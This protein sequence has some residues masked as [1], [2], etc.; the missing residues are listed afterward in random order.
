[1]SEQPV[2]ITIKPAKS[3]V[4]VRKPDGS[5]LKADGE[6]VTKNAF[7]VRRLNDGDVELVKSTKVEE[8]KAETKKV[9]AKK[10]ANADT[11]Q[12]E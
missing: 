6:S 3:G 12:G 5:K 4:N 9:D 1:M 7:W 2:T 10:S 8:T 11:T